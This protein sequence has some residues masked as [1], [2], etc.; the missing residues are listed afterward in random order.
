LAHPVYYDF[1]LFCAEQTPVEVKNMPE[2]SG[3]KLRTLQCIKE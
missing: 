2:T 3:L 1:L